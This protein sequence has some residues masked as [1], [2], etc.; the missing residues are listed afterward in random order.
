N[1][2]ASVVDFVRNPVITAER[3]ERL[4]HVF[5]PNKGETYEVGTKTAKIFS[6]RVW[7]GSFGNARDLAPPGEREWCNAV[8]A[9]EGAEVSH[10]ATPPKKDVHLHVPEQGRKANY[11]AFVV[12]PSGTAKRASQ[13]AEVRNSVASGFLLRGQLNGKQG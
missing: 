11:L 8:R 10:H 7:G 5:L 6:Q 13:R 1:Q 3:G 4:H 12:H 2:L 9:S